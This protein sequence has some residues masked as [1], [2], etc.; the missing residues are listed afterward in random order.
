M[1]MTE[2]PPKIPQTYVEATSIINDSSCFLTFFLAF[3]NMPTSVHK[4]QRANL[5]KY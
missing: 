1:I 2:I 5:M 4:G 3:K